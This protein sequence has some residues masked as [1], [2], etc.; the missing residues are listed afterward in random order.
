MFK[1]KL[2]FFS[3]STSNERISFDNE[4]K[5]MQSIESD[6]YK[7][8]ILKQLKKLKTVPMK[9]SSDITKA[10]YSVYK[11]IHILTKE[12]HVLDEDEFKRLYGSF[13]RSEYLK[14]YSTDY[15][16]F[17]VHKDKYDTAYTIKFCYQFKEVIK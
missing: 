7:E 12:N 13:I 8:S 3:K 16:V 9:R 10:I 2:P 14:L 5:T 15:D 6:I 17:F 4:I 1:L 11:E